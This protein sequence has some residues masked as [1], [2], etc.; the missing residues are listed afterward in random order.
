MGLR[1]QESFRELSRKLDQLEDLSV[2]TKE[3]IPKVHNLLADIYGQIRTNPALCAKTTDLQLHFKN[4][5]DGRITLAETTKRQWCSELR[6]T[7]K[8]LNYASVRVIMESKK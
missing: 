8:G 5:I 7:L 3:Q 6:E 4:L 2:E 1:N